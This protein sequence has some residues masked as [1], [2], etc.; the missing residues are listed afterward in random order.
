MCVSI[1]LLFSY[2][3]MN[4]LPK[5]GQVVARTKRRVT[6]WMHTCKL[7]VLPYCEFATP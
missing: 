4:P 3:V 5:P 1:Y 7:T 6:L 2:T